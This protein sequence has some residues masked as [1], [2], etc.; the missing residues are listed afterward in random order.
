MPNINILYLPIG[1][2]TFDLE[3]GEIY[4]KESQIFLEEQCSNVY[5]PD[6]ILN[7][8]DNMNDFLNRISKD[9]IHIF[10]YHS[11][12]FADDEF[13]HKLVN[14]FSQP[15]IVWSVREPVVGQ[16]HKLKSLTG[17]K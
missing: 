6:N 16:R 9:K 17:G 5:A 11:I 10:I 1:R 14:S 8:V 15:V 12:T 7:S 4:R 13:N 2:K 3:S